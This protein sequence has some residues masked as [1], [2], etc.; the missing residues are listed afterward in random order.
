MRQG[1]NNNSEQVS[2]L[3]SFLTEQGFSVP[4]TG[5]FGPMTTDAVKQFQSTHASEV[6]Q[7]W[8]DAGLAADLTP[9]GIVF[10]TT[11]Y[12]INNIVCEGSESMPVL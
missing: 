10:K 9:T 11:R 6:L 7:P 1:G 5:F 4:T 8:V 3:Q 2:K 12:K